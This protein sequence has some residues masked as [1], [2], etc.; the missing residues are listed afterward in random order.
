MIFRWTTMVTPARLPRRRRRAIPKA[1][2]YSRVAVA[3]VTLL[4]TTDAI[5]GIQE[6]DCAYAHRSVF[7]ANAGRAV[8]LCGIELECCRKADSGHGG[9]VP[10]H[11]RGKVTFSCGISERSGS[12]CT[13][14]GRAAHTTSLPST[15]FSGGSALPGISSNPLRKIRR[16]FWPGIRR[17]ALGGHPVH[18][19]LHKA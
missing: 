17:R 9:A 1:W 13:I 16:R 18:S 12:C 3:S 11:R 5:M 10:D 7:H 6:K 4:F 2:V 19:R 8:P 15:I 14:T